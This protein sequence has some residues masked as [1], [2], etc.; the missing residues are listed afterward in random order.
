MASRFDDDDNQ[1]PGQT[2][3]DQLFNLSKSESKGNFNNPDE[4]EDI[5]SA[6]EDGD[7]DI[8]NNVQGKDSGSSGGGPI[9]NFLLNKLKLNKDKWPIII[10]ILMTFGGGIGML[11]V[12]TPGLAIMQFEKIFT[13][14]LD[15][16][17]PALNIRT[18]R[19]LANK[20]KST[21]GAFALT[22]DGKC[23][24]KCKFGSINEKTVKKYKAQGFEIEVREGTGLA[25][26]RYILESMTFPNTGDG[27]QRP[28]KTGN[29]FKTAM[30]NPRRAAS[31]N[32]VFNPKTNFFTNAIFSSSIKSKFGL[33]KLSNLTAKLKDEAKN[34][35][36]SSRDKVY[37]SIRERLGLPPADPNVKL[38][39]TEKIKSDPKFKPYFEFANG[40]AV[41][42]ADGGVSLVSK[43]CGAYNI[44]RGM[45][46]AVKASKAAALAGYGMMFLA[47]AGKLTA[48]EEVEPEVTET[49][50]AIITEPDENNVTATSSSGYRMAA[51][52]EPLPLSE[53][54]RK[55]SL[56]N[57]SDYLAVLGGLTALLGLTGVAGY[58]FYHT[59]CYFAGNAVLDVAVSCPA[60]AAT[61]VAGLATAGVITAFA[62]VKCAGTVI[63]ID[64]MANIAIGAFL[65][66]I[67]GAIVA[68]ELPVLDETLRGEATGAASYTASAQI[69]GGKSA[70]YGLKPGTKDDIKNYRIA[71]ADIRQNDR[72]IAMHEASKTPFDIYNKDSFLGSIIQNQNISML[73]SASI[74]SQIKNLVSFLP[75]SLASLNNS[76]YAEADK[77]SNLYGKCDDPSLK[78]INVD[79]DAY[80]NASYVMSESELN[81]DI[82]TVV[83]YMIDNNYIDEDTGEVKSESKPNNYQKYLDNCA[84]RVDPLGETSAAIEE[85]EPLDD[86]Y[87]WKIGLKCTENNEMMSNFRTYTM[88]K[89]ISDSLDEEVV[90]A[91]AN[92]TIDVANLYKASDN[93]AC[94]PGT[95]EAV[96]S[97]EIRLDTGEKI[98][99]KLCY[100]PNTS[101]SDSQNRTFDSVITVNSRVSGAWLALIN[102]MRTATGDNVIS[103]S[104]SFRTYDMQMTNGNY[105]SKHET[106]IAVD[107]GSLYSCVGCAI[108]GKGEKKYFDFLEYDGGGKKHGF[109][110]L[111][112][113]LEAWHWEPIE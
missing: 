43:V 24:V 52:N 105:W 8:I 53:E 77:K 104:S 75:K 40:K 113:P 73:S 59:V 39:T 19:M 2:N 47:Y 64:A 3:S 111:R 63:A 38:S 79:G 33:D 88:D 20:F 57:T 80:C 48:G 41:K 54:N 76:V 5:R 37:A 18:R 34:K 10:A 99:I 71:T 60:E 109:Q 65:S 87:Q 50:G 21:A 56:T 84:N 27:P 93:I 66:A 36:T 29:D 72:D 12:L 67:T 107:F 74:S 103:S 6:E 78:A 108:P 26:G 94:A 44:A 102:E 58:N 13:E 31:F 45:T 101:D 70:T 90:N 15:D 7:N 32:K 62:F 42:L 83:Q 112:S 86:I 46:Y 9:S 92:S 100:I 82:N 35:T 23:G 96:A 51:Y 25:K 17:S 30:K 22:S 85:G 55:Y 16:S 89:A 98:K 14:A 28:I 95:T 69:L 91:T 110:Y 68:K 4:S 81:A 49:I 106:G 11:T 61:A 97:Q 1:N